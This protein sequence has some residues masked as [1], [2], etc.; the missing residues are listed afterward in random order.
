MDNALLEKQITN[1]RNNLKTDRLDMS[2]GEI[3]NMYE[4]EEIIISPDFQRLFRWSIEQQTRFIE[5]ILLGIPIP[6]I[7]VA[8]NKTG[9]W[10]LVDGL[11]RISTILSYLGSLRDYNNNKWSL[12][13]GDLIPALEGYTIDELPI[14]YARNIKRAVCRVEIIKWDS[15]WDMRYELFS[16]LNTGGTPLTEQ[17]IRNSIFRSELKRFYKF[18]E[19]ASKDTTFLE[20]VNLTDKQKSEKY[21]E[22]LVVRFI[23]MVN[24]WQSIEVKIQKHMTEYMQ[25]MSKAHKDLDPEIELL[26]MNIIQLLKPIGKSIF[27]YSSGKVFSPNLFDGIMISLAKFYDFYSKNPDKICIKIQELKEDDNFKEFSG[28]S[29]YS[30]TRIKKSMERALEIFG[31]GIDE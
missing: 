5:S 3:M 29:T 9:K 10:E 16:R 21:N 26:F 1:M 25:K 13:S 28:S 18:V 22:E 2:F 14:Q 30:K 12:L 6:S 31:D 19:K 17:E 27:R 15:S 24:N 23:S 11:Q 20:L 4:R 8:E 7:F